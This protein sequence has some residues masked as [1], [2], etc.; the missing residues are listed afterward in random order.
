LGCTFGGGAPPGCNIE[1]ARQD[2][3]TR[4]LVFPSSCDPFGMNTNGE[5]IFVMHPD[6][7]GLQQLSDTR[8]FTTEADGTVDVELPGPFA[9]TAV[10]R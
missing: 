10:R 7:S 1:P 4:A 6:G 3:V 9:S 2:P 8:G 5:Q